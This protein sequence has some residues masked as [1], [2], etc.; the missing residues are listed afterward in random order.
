MK[1]GRDIGRV[2]GGL[3]RKQVRL[4]ASVTHPHI[5]PTTTMLAG[6]HCSHAIPQYTQQQTTILAWSA[7]TASC[8]NPHCRQL[9]TFH[10]P[11][12]RAPSSAHQAKTRLAL[13]N[14]PLSSSHTPPSSYTCPAQFNPIPAAQRRSVATTGTAT[15]T[16]TGCGVGDRCCCCCCCEGFPLEDFSLR[17]CGCSS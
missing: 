14:L 6:S 12:Q 17:L 2:G 16:G 10:V 11:P 15:G 13:F 5:S 3:E 8:S 1:K 4:H 7:E 9:R